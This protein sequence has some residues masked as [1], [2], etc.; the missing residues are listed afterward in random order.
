MV[1]GG[2]GPGEMCGIRRRKGAMTRHG[3]AQA[4]V[5]KL[6]A[7]L[8][9]GRLPSILRR[10]LLGVKSPGWLGWRVDSSG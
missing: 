2:K 8:D 5:D 10:G 3:R 4:G 6:A 9:D 7:P 1:F